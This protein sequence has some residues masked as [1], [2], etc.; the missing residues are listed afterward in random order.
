MLYFYTSE[1]THIAIADVSLDRHIW[2][3]FLWHQLF[4]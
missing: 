2:L 1:R 3:H 4:M